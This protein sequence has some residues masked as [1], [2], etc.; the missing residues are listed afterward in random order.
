VVGWPEIVAATTPAAL[1]L[2]GGVRWLL[3]W[4]LK[5]RELHDEKMVARF[6]KLAQTFL[7]ELHQTNERAKRHRE[8]HLQDA[9]M[10]AEKM[11]EVASLL[12]RVSPSRD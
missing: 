11:G 6:E 8:E 9:R 10:Y 2:G 12:E 3:G 7:A 5:R 1:G 4:W